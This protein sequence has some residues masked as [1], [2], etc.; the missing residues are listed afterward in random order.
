MR[1]DP[2]VEALDVLEDLER[3]PLAAPGKPA[4]KKRSKKPLAAA[5]AVV[6]VAAAGFSA[7]RLLTAKP[8]HVA[9]QDQGDT[10]RFLV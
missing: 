1:P 6:L 7:W 8:A 4:K 5:V 2:V 10:R 3:R 9:E